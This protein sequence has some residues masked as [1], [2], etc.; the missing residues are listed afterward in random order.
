MH[1]SVWVALI[2]LPVVAGSVLALALNGVDRTAYRR[3]ITMLRL[4][5]DTKLGMHSPK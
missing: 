4:E 2:V 3:H 5:F 1:Y